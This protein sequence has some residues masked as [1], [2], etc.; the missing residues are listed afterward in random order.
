MKHTSDKL[1]HDCKETLRGYEQQPCG[2]LSEEKQGKM[3]RASCWKR[4]LVMLS[5]VLAPEWGQCLNGSQGWQIV[6][7]ACGITLGFKWE[8][9]VLMDR[10]TGQIRSASGGCNSQYARTR[11][12]TRARTH[13]RW[14]STSS[15]NSESQL[16]NIIGG[17][18][19]REKKNKAWPAQ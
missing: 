5:S 10:L 18:I 1:Q 6:Q 2:S 3:E 13:T 11:A 16:E 4:E 19:P 9:A 14:C 8:I 7:G 15:Y 12:H 17:I